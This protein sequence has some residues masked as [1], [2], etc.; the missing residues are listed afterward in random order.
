MQVRAA[1]SLRSLAVV[2]NDLQLGLEEEDVPLLFGGGG[3]ELREL[4]LFLAP[5]SVS[6]GFCLALLQRC[7][8]LGKLALR[9][10]VSPAVMVQVV[11]HILQHNL[12]VTLE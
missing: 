2:A 4:K 8:H 1:P 7:P 9:D 3:A 10:S 5:G 12:D 11:L 6:A